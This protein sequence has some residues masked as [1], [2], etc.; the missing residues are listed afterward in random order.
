M[1]RPHRRPEEPDRDGGGGRPIGWTAWLPDAR[2]VVAWGSGLAMGYLLGRRVGGER[3]EGREIEIE[4]GT[5]EGV[6]GEQGQEGASN[7]EDG[8]P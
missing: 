1:I 6:D 3:W 4:D 5:A 7:A 2:L 8:E